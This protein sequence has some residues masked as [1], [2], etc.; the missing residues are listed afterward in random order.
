[1]PDKET[2]VRLGRAIYLGIAFLSLL[3]IAL[4]VF[5]FSVGPWHDILINVGSG[6]LTASL[7]FFLVYEYFRFDPQEADWKKLHAQLETIETSLSR[8]I[9]VKQLVGTNEIY[10]SAGI[11]LC[12][13]FENRLQA[14]VYTSGPKAPQQWVET[15]A[16]RLKDLRK[17]GLS[18]TFEVVLVIDKS[19]LASDFFVTTFTER[20]RIYERHGVFDLV[21]IRIIDSKPEVGFDVLIMDSRHV[22]LSFTTKQ[23]VKIVEKGLLFEDKPE[24]AQPFS[25]WFDHLMK[26]EATPY[27]QWKQDNGY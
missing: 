7:V 12:A 15:V 1:M 6:L 8:A 13:S 5:A 3:L 19:S 24:I 22:I 16:K 10:L 4:G 27:L 14:V 18:P 17:Q 20:N 21:D 23:N 26:T 11:R 2:I 9:L 25:E